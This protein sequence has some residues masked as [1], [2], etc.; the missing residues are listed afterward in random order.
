MELDNVEVELVDN[1]LSKKH[2]YGEILWK[3]AD[4]H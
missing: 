4:E 1:N 3:E 2:V